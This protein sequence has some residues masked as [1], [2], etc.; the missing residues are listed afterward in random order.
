MMIAVRTNAFIGR[1]SQ[2]GRAARSLAKSVSSRD[3]LADFCCGLCASDARVRTDMSAF[4]GPFMPEAIVQRNIVD[5]RPPY[6]L[7]AF[8][9]LSAPHERPNSCCA[10]LRDTAK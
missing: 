5:G 2:S 4:D 8:D 6:A 7:H 10:S 1:V 9:F 3:G